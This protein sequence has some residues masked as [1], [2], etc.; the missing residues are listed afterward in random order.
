[1]KPA[2]RGAALLAVA[3]LVALGVSWLRGTEE[4]VGDGSV[5]TATELRKLEGRWQR[6]DGGYV[7]EIRRV[8]NGGTTMEAAYY[9]P[10]PIHV[11]LAE[12]SR[13]GGTLKVLIELRDANYPGSTYMLAYDPASDQLRGVYYQAVERQRFPVALVRVR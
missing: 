2:V 13:E 11:A 9:N 1:M 5:A 3:L 10:R 4:P 6:L 8:G 7:I 12:V